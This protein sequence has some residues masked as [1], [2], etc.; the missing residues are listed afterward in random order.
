MVFSCR[1]TQC[2]A[3]KLTKLRHAENAQEI[4]DAAKTLES[5]NLQLITLIIFA[6]FPKKA[7]IL[8][9]ENN[10]IDYRDK[11]FLQEQCRIHDQKTG[12]H[13]LLSQFHEIFPSRGLTT[14]NSQQ[15]T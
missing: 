5:C 8:L 12:S 10:N 3:E 15:N 11:I 2:S 9:K 13:D 1:I 7:L 4:K 6:N 14:V